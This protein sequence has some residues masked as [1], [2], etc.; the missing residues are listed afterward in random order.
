MGD[1]E[2]EGRDGRLVM[3]KIDKNEGEMEG[4]VIKMVR[5]EK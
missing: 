5:I 3:L 1:K 2:Y 4:R